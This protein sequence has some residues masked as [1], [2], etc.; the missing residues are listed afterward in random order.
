MVTQRGQGFRNMGAGD[1]KMDTTEEKNQLELKRI[2][3]GGLIIL[4]VGILTLIAS[5]SS[6]FVYSDFIHYEEEAQNAINHASNTNGSSGGSS[7][8]G[9]P[10]LPLYADIVFIGISVILIIIGII[11]IARSKRKSKVNSP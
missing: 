6:L 1:N 2:P 9:N 8:G 4:I 3:V 11:L 10:Y 7:S 5:I